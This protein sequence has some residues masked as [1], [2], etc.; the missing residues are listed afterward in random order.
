MLV[1]LAIIGIKKLLE[2][3]F[4]FIAASL[5][6]KVISLSMVS[7]L[8]AF[9]LTQATAGISSINAFEKPFFEKEYQK[10]IDKWIVENTPT[11]AKIATELP[12]AVL[13]NT[14]REAVNFFYAYK[15]DVSY[16]RWIIKK[17]DID[18]LV[19][20]FSPNELSITDLG[21]MKLDLVY[22]AANSSAY[23]A[24][25]SSAYQGLI[26]KVISK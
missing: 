24:P 3:P 23:Q 5:Q 9:S 4:R 6:S 8:V 1:P 14:G 7:I 11:D 2:I 19:F 18:Y 20:Y 26:Y 15:D 22:K 13:L 16:E 12:H 21:E 17:F 10:K 25:N